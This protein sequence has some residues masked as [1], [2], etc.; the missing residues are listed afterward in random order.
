MEG[1]CRRFGEMEIGEDAVFLQSVYEYLTSTALSEEVYSP[2]AAESP[3][4]SFFAG[5]WNAMSSVGLASCRLSVS[6]VK[7]LF[8]ATKTMKDMIVFMQLHCSDSVLSE[9]LSHVQKFINESGIARGSVWHMFVQALIDTASTSLVRN[10]YVQ[11]LTPHFSRRMMLLLR[12]AR[13]LLEEEEKK[14]SVCMGD[15]RVPLL[16]LNAHENKSKPIEEVRRFVANGFRGDNP[17][18]VL[19]VYWASRRLF[20]EE[21]PQAAVELLQQFSRSGSCSDTLV[22]LQSFYESIIDKL[23]LIHA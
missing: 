17:I 10:E 18:S 11:S 14:N 13:S 23:R 4:P 3:F 5:F 2:V 22:Q 9:S 19:D 1:L 15:V 20:L 21:S 12:N 7:L 16:T 8:N 6:R